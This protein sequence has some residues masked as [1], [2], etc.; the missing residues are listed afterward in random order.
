[1][2]PTRPKQMPPMFS[3]LRSRGRGRQ[4]GGRGQRGWGACNVP[5]CQRESPAQGASP[6]SPQGRPL[7]ARAR[8]APAHKRPPTH[9]HTNNKA[10]ALV[11]AASSLPVPNGP[12]RR[13]GSRPARQPP[14]HPAEPSKT[15]SSR[16]PLPS[17]RPGPHLYL[18]SEKRTMPSAVV[19]MSFI[20]PVT[21]VAS[22]ELTSVHLRGGQQGA[23][24]QG[25]L[26]SGGSGGRGRAGLGTPPAGCGAGRERLWCTELP[27]GGGPASARAGALGLLWASTR[28]GGA[29]S[30]GQRG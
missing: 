5:A 24:G 25:V 23:G 13:L 29:E 1:M 9:T 3:M 11:P 30:K 6:Q 7:H 22:G 12:S 18:T 19:R 4:R 27:Q 10:A 21:L 26:A 20:C 8:Q 16:Q 28:Q 17:A 2:E 14:E 15:A